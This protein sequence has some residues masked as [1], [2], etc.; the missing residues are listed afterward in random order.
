MIAQ[1][2]IDFYNENGYVVLED[3]QKNLQINFYR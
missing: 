2:D 3:I 1:K